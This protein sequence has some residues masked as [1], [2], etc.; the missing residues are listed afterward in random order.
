[1]RGVNGLRLHGLRKRHIA[2]LALTACATLLLSVTTA[3]TVL[4]Q[5]T[6]GVLTPGVT[7]PPDD[8]VLREPPAMITMSFR[9]EVRLLK[10][11]LQS[12]EGETVDIGFT[13]DPVRVA[14]SFVVPVPVELPPSAYYTA[15]WSVL[16][17]RQRLVSGEFNFSFGPDAI[18]PS[19]TIESGYRPI[20]EERIP[21]S[22]AYQ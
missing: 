8:S 12:S 1:M 3:Q 2:R 22:G 20:T 11:A 21:G 13:Y 14:D 9:V 16:D 10:L 19:E 7:F 15:R 5:H 17:D 18:P 6:H 4:A